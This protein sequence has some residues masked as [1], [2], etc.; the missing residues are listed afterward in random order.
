MTRAL[1]R[2]DGAQRSE[3]VSQF[4]ALDRRRIQL[5][6]SEVLARYLERRPNGEAGEMG[7]VR[8]EI[9]KKRPSLPIRKLMEQ[10]GSAVQKLKPVF[11]MSPLSVCAIPASRSNEFRPRGYR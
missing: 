4:R 11:M 2:I 10:A 5:A 8:A 1:T 6:R 9:G 7:V 3:V